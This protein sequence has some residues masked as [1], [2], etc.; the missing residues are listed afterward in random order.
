MR[1]N[2][3]KFDVQDHG[4]GCFVLRCNG[5]LSWEDREMLTASVEDHIAGAARVRGVVLDLSNVEYINSAGLGALFQLVRNLRERSARLAFSNVPHTI[6]RLFRIVGLDTVSP[7][8]TDVAAAL[9]A[10]KAD[11]P[12]TPPKSR[13]RAKPAADPAIADAARFAAN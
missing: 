6:G 3:I 2:V 4:D 7:P 1:T 12:G 8:H 5:G 10:L 9:A 13:R 11:A